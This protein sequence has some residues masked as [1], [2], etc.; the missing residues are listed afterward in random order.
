MGSAS[1]P[2]LLDVAENESMDDNFLI[3]ITLIYR[4]VAGGVMVTDTDL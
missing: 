4:V 2:P 3:F 1:L